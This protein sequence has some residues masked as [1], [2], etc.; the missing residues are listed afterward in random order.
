RLSTDLPIIIEVVDLPE[1]IEK[2]KPKLDNI[3][4]QGL[5]TQE[6]VKIIM[7]EGTAEEKN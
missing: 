3:I 4:K 7:Y 5:I 1:I 6:K 2:I